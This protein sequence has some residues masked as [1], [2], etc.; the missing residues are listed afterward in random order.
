MNVIDNNAAANTAAAGTADVDP[1]ARVGGGWGVGDAGGADEGVVRC[2]KA[3]EG[4]C[5]VLRAPARRKGRQ[6][7]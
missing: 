2:G 5:V 1:A 6:G 3:H 7:V 4:D